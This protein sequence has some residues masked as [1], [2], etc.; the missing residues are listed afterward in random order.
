[1]MLSK[2]AIYN[3]TVPR[4]DAEE[5]NTNAKEEKLQ[6]ALWKMIFSEAED[7]E[8]LKRIFVNYFAM[9][10]HFKNYIAVKRER[11]KDKTKKDQE[12]EKKKGDL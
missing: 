2:R 10:S 11:D 12:S 1:M 7:K 8:Y 9:Q 3:L 5:S 6:M 4:T